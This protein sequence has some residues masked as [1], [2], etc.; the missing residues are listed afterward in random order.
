MNGFAESTVE[1]AALEW[2]VGVGWEVLH[3]PDIS[4]GP[5]AERAGYADVVPERRLRDA[6][7]RLNPEL[8]SSAL[9]GAPE[10]I[11]SCPCRRW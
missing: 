2:L 4:T 8:P 5:G 10:L 6:V 9:A 11:V 3:G 7:A 1:E